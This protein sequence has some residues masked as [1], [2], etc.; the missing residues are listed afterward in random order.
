MHL[1][2]VQLFGSRRVRDEANAGA[3]AFARIDSPGLGDLEDAIIL[4]TFGEVPED[5]ECLRP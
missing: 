5:F 1:E 3:V 2:G 4:K